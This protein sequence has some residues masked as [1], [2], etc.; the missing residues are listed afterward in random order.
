MPWR[1]AGGCGGQ[2]ARGAARHGRA[3]LGHHA[4]GGSGGDAMGRAL[5]GRWVG[6]ALLPLH[7]YSCAAVHHRAWQDH[8]AVASFWACVAPHPPRI[9]LCRCTTW[10]AAWVQYS[11]CWRTA[12]LRCMWRR[13]PACPAH[14][15]SMPG[16]S[17]AARAAVQG[18]CNAGGWKHRSDGM[19]R[20]AGAALPQSVV[21]RTGSAADCS[22]VCGVCCRPPLAVSAAQGSEC[23]SALSSLRLWCSSAIGEL[24][25]AADRRW[26][27]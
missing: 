16:S 23:C 12:A 21:A 14:P 25:S 19:G 18:W 1:G 7:A 3:R 9:P 22:S 13:T 5:W 17:A 10:A 26:A 24:N 4:P 2:R 15:W 20:A 8:A 6:T 27:S 11:G